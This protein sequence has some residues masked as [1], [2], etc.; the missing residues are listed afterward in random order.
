MR[1]TPALRT[2]AVALLTGG[3][4][5]VSTAGGTAYAG[6]GGSSGP[7]W[8]TVVS[9]TKLDV[10]QSPTVHSHVVARLA[11]GSQVRI[12]CRVVGQSVNGNP[13]WYRL[14]GVQA[15][16]SAAFVHTNW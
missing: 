7:I 2:L 1:T 10:R 4:L 8:G 12:D 14:V 15:W 9:A 13:Y 6:S 3:S 11:P 5:A 16:A